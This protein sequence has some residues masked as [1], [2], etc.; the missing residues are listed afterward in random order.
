MS[1]AVYRSLD[2]GETRFDGNI[3]WRHPVERMGFVRT[4]PDE[5][6]EE[7]WRRWCEKAAGKVA[8]RREVVLLVPP[9]SW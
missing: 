9:S 2:E 6:W 5:V 8:L 4:E 7:P 1:A 3:A